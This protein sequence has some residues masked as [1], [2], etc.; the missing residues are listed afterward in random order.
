MISENKLSLLEEIL[1]VIN[2]V[3]SPEELLN[4]LIDRYIKITG[5]LTGSVMI[6]NPET[7]V[8]EMK[9]S[10]GLLSEKIPS[11]KLKIGQ[12]VTGKVAETGSSLLIKDTSTIDYYIRIR[13]DLKSELAVPLKLEN[14]IIGVIS[15]DSDRENAFTEEHLDILETISNFVA[16][17]LNKENL[18][19]NLK[20]KISKHC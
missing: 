16:Q 18:I 17:I 19:K 7:K 5:A 1:S 15:V 6:I 14:E 2:S 13:E 11:V 20:D 10:R 8:L 3:K 9:A 12:G 4:Y